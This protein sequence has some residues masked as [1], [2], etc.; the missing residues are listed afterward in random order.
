[1]PLLYN[2]KTRK[3]SAM[4]VYNKKGAAAIPVKQMNIS[5]FPQNQVVNIYILIINCTTLVLPYSQFHFP[6]SSLP[7]FNHGVKILTGKFQ[8]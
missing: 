4:I 3:E 1:M 8:K 5:P 6:R 7:A 2:Y